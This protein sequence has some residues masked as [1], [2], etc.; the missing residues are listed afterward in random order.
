MTPQPRTPEPM[1]LY[2]LKIRSLID[3]LEKKQQL[4]DKAFDRAALL[5]TVCV[6]LLLG[7]FWQQ[8]G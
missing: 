8:I 4:V 3:Q 1:H 2:Q 6:L 7:I 5:A